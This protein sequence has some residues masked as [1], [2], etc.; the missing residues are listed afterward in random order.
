MKTKTITLRISPETARQLDAL[1]QL[2]G[3]TQSDVIRRSIQSVYDREEINMNAPKTPYDR[4]EERVNQSPAL[5]KHAETI[6]HDWP[7]GD[8]H[9]KWVKNAPVGEIVSWAED[10]ESDQY[11]N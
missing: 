10:I 9:W 7:E 8:E 6:L 2:W 11:T 1:Q 4:A 3:E 5:S